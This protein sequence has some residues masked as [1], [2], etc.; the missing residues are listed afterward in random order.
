MEDYQGI[1]SEFTIMAPEQGMLIYAR[2]WDGKKRVVGSTVS[3]WDPT[4]ATLPDLTKMESI[5]YVNEVD[6]QKIKV[7]QEV[8]VSLDANSDKR[9]TG[10]VT[11][12]AN[13]GEQRPNSDS[14]VF[15]VKIQINEKD[16]TLRP[17]MTTS[18]EIIISTMENVMS[19]PLECV[20][21]EQDSISFVYVRKG[22]GIERQ[23][24]KL[25]VENENF[26]IVEQ[27]VDADAELYLSKPDNADALELKRLAGK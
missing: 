26:V 5:T 25:G 9:L 27:G 23:Q 1:L 6:I 2:E 18:N 10:K 19:I 17:A 12:V 8:R 13:V 22:G 24:V 21:V 7:G 14:K 20:H 4:V 11:Q 16:S 15:E 3:H